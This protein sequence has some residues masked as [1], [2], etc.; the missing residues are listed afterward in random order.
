MQ[1]LTDHEVITLSEKAQRQVHLISLKVQGNLP[2]CSHTKESRVKKHFRG[3]SISSRK[4]K[5]REQFLR[6]TE[7]IK[8]AEAKS[9]IFK[10]ECKV[11]TL[12]TCI[13]KFQRQARSNRLELDGVHC[14]YE[15]SRRDQ[16]R[17]HEELARREK[18]P[19]EP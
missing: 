6:N 16:A 11:D 3:T 8:L 18:A 17:L 7:I 13:R 15:D 14:G 10:Q 12:N 1:V 9:E 4:V 2:Q 19:R 5:L